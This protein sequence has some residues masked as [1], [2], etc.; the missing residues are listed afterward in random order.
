MD[1]SLKI[2]Q[3][4][5]DF[6]L[7]NE[8]KNDVEY[9]KFIY[10]SNNCFLPNLSDK[11]PNLTTLVLNKSKNL[12]IR[13][14]GL[15]FINLKSLSLCDCNLYDLDGISCMPNLVDLQL[16]DN[17]ISDISSLSNLDYLEV[18]LLHN[19]FKIYS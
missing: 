15:G 11:L 9:L 4:E 19:L 18:C 6:D 3:S 7:D 2:I 1:D 17:F 5:D 12:C 10:N 16:A 13:D 14:F 8:N